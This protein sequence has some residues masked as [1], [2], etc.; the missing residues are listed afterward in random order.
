MYSPRKL[1]IALLVLAIGLLLAD[2]CGADVAYVASYSNKDVTGSATT[3]TISNVNCGAGALCKFTL[4]WR[5]NSGQTAST[6]TYGGSSTGITLIVPTVPMGGSSA[7][8][9][10]AGVNI[11]CVR[12]WYACGLTGTQNVVF[13]VSAAA[14]TLAAVDVYTGVDCAGTPIGTAQQS[15]SEADGASQTNAGPTSVTTGAGGMAADSLF[16]LDDVA[17]TMVIG[18]GQT[19]RSYQG[20][21]GSFSMWTSDEPAS[22]GMSWDWSP[23]ILAYVHIVTPINAGSSSGGGGGGGGGS[24]GPG[25]VSVDSSTSNAGAAVTVH[26]FAF[27]C[28]AGRPYLV[29]IALFAASVSDIT[30]VAY[31]S[32][33]L[34]L[35]G[36]AAGTG[37]DVAIIYRRNDGAGCDGASHNVVITYDEEAANS[38]AVA[39]SFN[40][41]DDTTPF[42]DYTTAGPTAAD[43]ISIT[44]PNVTTGDMVFTV[45]STIN[46]TTVTTGTQVAQ[47][48][49]SH[50][51][52][53][54][55]R[56]DN[57]T[58][59]G[60]QMGAT[61]TWNVAGIRINETAGGTS[62]IGALTLLKAGGC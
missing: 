45:W 25:P 35:A 54:V 18:S 13:T 24:S 12:T 52:T 49:S 3:V 47:I 55:R 4:V 21:V 40:G 39:I 31:N 11:G 44:V 46:A 34:T 37:N 61:D 42:T 41:V 50:F 36:T 22:T 10:D 1:F 2:R 7:G 15:D 8:C 23:E 59:S 26:S 58:V 32:Q 43:A 48:G 20:D 29:G 57:G 51:G 62:C 27:T 53:F 14:Q 60:N 16:V 19:Q 28:T 56:A 38:N 6:P 9:G 17:P 5:A 30:S 33:A